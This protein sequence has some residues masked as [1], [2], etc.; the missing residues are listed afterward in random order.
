[1]VVARAFSAQPV[2]QRQGLR[3]ELSAELLAERVKLGQMPQASELQLA[4]EV[5]PI[6]VEQKLEPLPVA[7]PRALRVALQGPP[8]SAVARQ[9]RALLVL[10]VQKPLPVALA[11][12]V[13]LVAAGRLQAGAERP[14]G[15]GAPLLRRLPSRPFPAQPWQL[16]LLRLRPDR[17][18]ACGLSPRPLHRSS[19]SGSSFQ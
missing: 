14:Q 19:W 8:P 9:P 1:M 3:V 5:L 11:A 10:L 16:P 18:N 4:L 6:R 7:V 12:P 2:W 17:G 15:G 13:R